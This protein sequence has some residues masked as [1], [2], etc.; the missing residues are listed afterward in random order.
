MKTVFTL[1]IPWKG[2][3][4]SWGPQ[5]AFWEPVYLIWEFIEQFKPGDVCS[6]SRPSFS[7]PAW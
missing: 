4:D 2:L 5:M 6:F 1:Q 7:G 3:G